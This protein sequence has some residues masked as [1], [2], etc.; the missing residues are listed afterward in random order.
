MQ[1]RTEP[2]ERKAHPHQCR[3]LHRPCS[4]NSSS[5]LA[6]VH[7]DSSRPPGMVAAAEGQVTLDYILSTAAIKRTNLN[8]IVF[9]LV[10]EDTGRKDCLSHGS[11][12]TTAIFDEKTDEENVQEVDQHPL[13]LWL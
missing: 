7:G 6:E 2:R 1:G 10:L 5:Q 13:L 3:R 9:R 11:P 8:E 4:C 12:A